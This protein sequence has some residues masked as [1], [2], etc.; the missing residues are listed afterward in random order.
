MRRLVPTNAAASRCSHPH[1]QRAAQSSSFRQSVPVAQ[2]IL[3]WL[4][5]AWPRRPHYLRSASS[6]RS[7]AT[8][9]KVASVGPRRN[10]EEVSAART[11]PTS[12]PS[13]LDQF[14]WPL[15][16][17]SAA[18][19]A[20]WAAPTYLRKLHSELTARDV[21]GALTTYRR[22]ISSPEGR[23]RITHRVLRS[24]VHLV[25]KGRWGP[26]PVR[27]TLL[28]LD[29]MQR[30]GIPLDMRD[31][32]LQV[33]CYI[34]LQDDEGLRK[35]LFEMKENHHE[36][37]VTT[38]NMMLANYAGRGNLAAVRRGLQRMLAFGVR[39]DIVTYNTI[40]SA[41]A[42]QWEQSAAGEMASVIR[43]MEADNIHPDA[44][45][46]NV[47]IKAYM[48]AG[49]TEAGMTTLS[50]MVEAGFV[51]DAVTYRTIIAAFLRNRDA[52]SAEVHYHAMVRAGYRPPM[53]LLDRFL[54]VAAQ[55][56]DREA[57]ERWLQEISARGHN[58]GE[59]TK[60]SMIR[61]A[62]AECDLRQLENT[63]SLEIGPDPVASTD[64]GVFYRVTVIELLKR[65]AL[66]IVP[67]ACALLESKGYPIDPTYERIWQMMVQRRFNPITVA[68]DGSITYPPT[69]EPSA[70]SMQTDVATLVSKFQRKDFASIIIANRQI[71]TLAKLPETFPE[72]IALYHA[73]PSLG[74][75][76]TAESLSPILGGFARTPDME[77]LSAHWRDMDAAGLTPD[78]ACHNARVA[79]WLRAGNPSEATRA[80][81]SLMASVMPN[82]YT[83]RLRLNLAV[84][85]GRYEEAVHLAEEVCRTREGGAYKALN[86][87]VDKLC[88]DGRLED[89]HR[90]WLAT[91][92]IV[93]DGYKNWKT[94]RLVWYPSVAAL[95]AGHMH[96]GTMEA[97]WQVYRVA[98][99]DGFSFEEPLLLTMARILHGEGRLA[100]LEMVL[101][102]AVEKR[103][104]PGR[105]S[106]KSVVTLLRD[107]DGTMACRIIGRVIARAPV[108]P[109][110]GEAGALI[111]A[112]YAAKDATGVDLLVSLFLKHCVELER[113]LLH[114]LFASR[115]MSWPP[116]TIKQLLEYAIQNAQETGV[117]LGT[118]S[119][120]LALEALV[121]GD[122]APG[123]L[124]AFNYMSGQGML[125]TAAQRG[126]LTDLLCRTG[127]ADEATEVSS[128]GASA[129]EEGL[130]RGNLQSL[131]M[132]YAREGRMDQ[133]DATLDRLP[134]AASPHA[135][136][137]LEAIRHGHAETGLRVLQ[138]MLK[139]NIPVHSYTYV[140]M[141]AE[142][143]QRG[144]VD[145]AVDVVCSLLAAGIVP[146]AVVHNLIIKAY[147][148]AGRAREALDML[149][150]PELG[151]FGAAGIRLKPD[152]WAWNTIVAG[153]ARDRDW[154][155]LALVKDLMR[156]EG[157]N[158]D[159]ATC[160]SLLHC[161]R[162][163]E[164]VQALESE[165]EAMG[166]VRDTTWF[167][168]LGTVYARLGM[169]RHC[170]Q[171][172]KNCAAFGTW[173]WNLMLKGWM[174]VGEY[175]TC[176]RMYYD[177]TRHGNGGGGIRPDVVT[178][179][180]LICA[181]LESSQVADASAQ[182]DRW[183]AE[184][185]RRDL[186]PSKK[187]HNLLLMEAAAAK[188]PEL[189]ARRFDAMVLAKA[190]PSEETFVSLVL[191]ATEGETFLQTATHIVDTLMPAH[192]VRPSRLIHHTIV[193]ALAQ[194]GR[195]VDVQSWIER[196]AASG[197]DSND[198]VLHRALVQAHIASNDLL[199][200][201]A[202]IA[203]R[204]KQACMQS[205]A[206]QSEMRDKLPI[207]TSVSADSPPE[208][209][210]PYHLL[211]D[212]Y[213]EAGKPP[214]LALRT[215][216][217]IKVAAADSVTFGIAMKVLL[218]AGWHSAATALWEWAVEGRLSTRD[219]PDAE[220]VAHWTATAPPPLG[221]RL[222]GEA[223]ICSYID[224]TGLALHARKTA[225]ATADRAAAD[226]QKDPNAELH[227][228]WTRVLKL[229][230]DGVNQRVARFAAFPTENMCNSHI[231]ALMRC[232]ELGGGI[233]IFS[234]MDGGGGGSG[235]GDT[236]REGM[237]LAPRPTPKTIRTIVRPLLRGGK[238]KQ[239]AKVRAM[240]ARRWP[241]LVSI[242]DALV[243]EH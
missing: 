222:V 114:I 186:K 160:T 88:R 58:M 236:S 62:A 164:D 11:D 66:S 64:P 41:L 185:A 199:A 82:A 127:L 7:V 42:G 128:T 51:A 55:S 211:A 133:L 162:T 63:L 83:T 22:I 144:E 134:G 156:R 195:V 20:A 149:A 206:P 209:L 213:C 167:R 193:F 105:T 208:D 92:T 140:S 37:D 119:A 46:Y 171:A 232:G 163:F 30:L 129:L 158:P 77:S 12:A 221:R 184:M 35:V 75:A 72:A 215:L 170:E 9:S 139:Q 2:L 29:D 95:I 79:G 57:G 125:V 220:P 189:A 243:Q 190:S 106:W 204:A 93:E 50:S 10:G 196:M 148:R 223:F 84:A 212:A 230:G 176:E 197:L 32:N 142:L 78:V 94:A 120:A 102:K 121:A 80:M 44:I 198:A 146:D 107:Y 5:P 23:S 76:P 91:R 130:D 90:C 31:Y 165:V 228:L 17:G 122:D 27:A 187:T 108:K 180:T 157:V 174:T 104:Q 28:L 123:A 49:D 153:L 239:V 202:V 74:L 205:F 229:G 233:K 237:A 60:L 45:T 183:L 172:V 67:A 36:P 26:N 147:V 242:V 19:L 173:E 166:V 227:T 47:L 6:L 81:D 155:S 89:A 68:D 18:D 152:A 25:R 151:L 100:E 54:S 141:I 56:H 103:T 15:I 138:R 154:D 116:G 39:P 3:P 113:K 192:Q 238:A 137:I 161:A 203:N 145:I 240:I 169:P 61:L 118:R 24:L 34:Y 226:W 48:R 71:A 53:W 21:N 52:A 136:S 177:M 115:N 218:K 214:M 110:A 8:D 234:Q 224:S 182:V 188:D 87:V 101:S 207:P 99:E 175:Y 135:K 13:V 201:E 97:A 216:Q 112:S 181:A 143:A 191:A 200:A 70:L 14:H 194:A 43:Q 225:G 98:I 117:P 150:H 111:M 16:R 231:E 59:S 85:S 124:L 219:D 38:Y 210:I 69:A 65:N 109:S 33:E 96:A 178:F 86:T 132:M 217:R 179:N 168:T 4:L 241:D 40:L 235:G 131:A 159:L 1:P 73:L 126:R